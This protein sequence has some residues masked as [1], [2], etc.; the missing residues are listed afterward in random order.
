MRYFFHLKRAGEV[1]SDC[2]GEDLADITQAHAYGVRMAAALL[3]HLPELRSEPGW[4]IAIAREE[5]QPLLSILLASVEAHSLTRPASRDPFG[6]RPA[7]T[8]G[9]P[10]HF[11][12]FG[13]DWHG[14]KR[15]R[16]PRQ[17]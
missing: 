6:L 5:G 10:L 13:Y 3:R 17:S 16:E 8:A 12:V 9:T 4:Y 1:I 11:D 7:G 2:S 15:R 14:T